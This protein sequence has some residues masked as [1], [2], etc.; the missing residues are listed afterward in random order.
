MSKDHL[1]VGVTD[2]R[3][4]EA[5]DLDPSQVAQISWCQTVRVLIRP[6]GQKTSSQ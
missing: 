4:C 1:P 3:V 6:I 5:E 2:A